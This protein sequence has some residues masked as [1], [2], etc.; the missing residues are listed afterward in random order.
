M[1]RST[2]DVWNAALRRPGPRGPQ[3][4]SAAVRHGVPPTEA[5]AAIGRPLGYKASFKRVRTEAG[6]KRLSLEISWTRTD[7]GP[8]PADLLARVGEKF[9]VLS[10]ELEAER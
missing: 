1:S 5:V 2:P 4:A 6:G 9:P 10:F 3:S 7:G 8:P